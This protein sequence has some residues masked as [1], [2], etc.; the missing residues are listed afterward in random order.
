MEKDFEIN[1]K[2]YISARNA[3]S[4]T[5]YASDYIGQLCRGKKISAK[6]VGRNWYVCEEEILRHKDLYQK[7]SPR[8]KSS[9]KKIITSKKSQDTV[10]TR[11]RHAGRSSVVEKSKTQ[12]LEQSISKITLQPVGLTNLD[13]INDVASVFVS[14]KNNQK[15][16]KINTSRSS[17]IVGN[18]EYK[19]ENK[20]LLPILERRLDFNR[21]FF[22]LKKSK[23]N[24]IYGFWSSKFNRFILPISTLVVA[25]FF[26]SLSIFTSPLTVFKN[27]V[28]D[29]KNEMLDFGPNIYAFLGKNNIAF[30]NF[31]NNNSYT[32]SV[33]DSVSSGWNVFS[34]VVK[35]TA[36]F[37]ISPWIDEDESRIVEKQTVEKVVVVNQGSQKSQSKLAIVS[38]S[39]REYIDQQI[40]EL[41]NYVH[42]YTSSVFPAV[43]RYYIDRQNDTLADLMGRSSGSSSSS[44]TNISQWT[45]D[46]GYFT[47]Y[48][49]WSPHWATGYS[50]TTSSI[51]IGTTTPRFQ[52][53]VSSS[54][55]SQLA[56]SDA[57]ANFFAFRVTGDSLNIGTTSDTTWGTSTPSQ[58]SIA[59]SGFGTT[60]LRGLNISGQATS[61]SN[62]GVNITAGCFAINNTCVG[63]G[64]DTALTSYDAWTHPASGI[65]ATTSQITV[66]GLLSTASSTI[67]SSLYLSSLSQGYSFIGSN[68]LV[69]TVSTSTLAGQVFPF[70]SNT[71][72]NSTSTTLG[73]LNG[74]FSTASSTISGDFR[75]PALSQGFAYTGSTG[76]VNTIA[77]SSIQL[78]WFNNDSG[79]L[80]S[81]LQSYDAWTHPAVG[82]SATTSRI[83]LFGSASSTLFS[84]NQV[85]FGGTGTTT[86]TNAGWI[87][88]G[89]T[90]PF[91][92]LSVNSEAGNAAFVIGSTTATSF[93]VDQ[94][95]NVGIKTVTPNALLQ[96]NGKAIIGS[97]NGSS[98]V[99]YTSS[100]PITATFII[101]TSN[102]GITL[103]SEPPALLIRN[104]GSIVQNQLARIAFASRSAHAP[105]NPA[106]VIGADITAVFVG[107]GTNNGRSADLTFG[108]TYTPQTQATQER[109]RLTSIGNLGIG[110]TTPNYTLSSYS[111]LSPQFSLSQGPGVAQW[112]FRN[113]GGNLY[114][115]TT[116]LAGTATTSISALEISGSGFGTTTLRGLNISGQATSTSNVGYNVTNGCFAISGTCLRSATGNELSAYDAW[117]HPA[118]GKSATTSEIQITG[119]LLSTASSTISSDLFLSSLSQ[120]YSY[121]GSNG[122]VKTV[123][124]STL[125]G[126]V[127]P[128]TSNTNYNSTSTTLGLLNGFFSTASST[129]SSNFYLPSLSQGVLY[130]GSNG[131]TNTTATG[132]IT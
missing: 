51:G 1:G 125:A 121:I 58:L 113:A 81:A 75:L 117:T 97:A 38:G 94:N 96:V 54:T 74:F 10:I 7:N 29:T 78:S 89:T 22:D 116:T 48:D 47:S 16:R 64:L 90:S 99:Y 8:K 82:V 105:T 111:Y 119:G 36:R 73:F 71:N 120:G 85:W 52:L 37:V 92:Q 19:A 41:K 131:L 106:G 20:P 32:A 122:I 110:T 43:N 77:S 5:G 126:Q 63:G 124:T 49:A 25:L 15:D 102:T 95:G 65:S 34:N 112:T 128:F 21:V 91:A 46:T 83:Q 4:L 42:G 23:N 55:A 76:K 93:I 24:N 13:T 87:G 12:Q 28:D 127:F 107:D 130:N 84:A 66:S 17:E 103:E 45:N 104:N 123:S 6:L 129:I 86:I 109:M 115:S 62:V 132:T 14:L 11:K 31:S 60:T 98:T 88:Q 50:A 40:L 9:F 33:F 18:I 114:F 100:N 108:T 27:I 61:T 101:D 2:K 39:D 56:L 70:T 30:S 35:D 80:T 69:S 3:A 67:S 68:G 53:Q 26:V 118:S 79:F 59:S 72:Y 57:G 44:N